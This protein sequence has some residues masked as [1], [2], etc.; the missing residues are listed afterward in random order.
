MKKKNND[1]YKSIKGL[2]EEARTKIVRN[3]NSILV[4]THF[5]IGRMIVED[6]QKGKQRAGYAEKT[7]AQLSN[8]LAAEYGSG[9]SRSNLEYMRKF[10]LVYRKRISQPLG[11]KLNIDQKSQPRLGNLENCLS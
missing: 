1:L 7:L 4:Y 9:Y 11:G 8:D 10:Y 6:E 3:V 2:I 5:E